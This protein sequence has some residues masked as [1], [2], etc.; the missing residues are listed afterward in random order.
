MAYVTLS[1]SLRCNEG[2]PYEFQRTLVTHIKAN[3]EHFGSESKQDGVPYLNDAYAKC[4][5]LLREQGYSR[6][7]ESFDIKVVDTRSRILG[8][9]HPHTI[10]AMGQLAETY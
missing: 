9:E 3:M 1:C 8:V 2:Q 5:K 10:N 6:E 7:A 4:G